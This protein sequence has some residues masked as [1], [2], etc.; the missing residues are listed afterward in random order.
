VYNN[1]GTLKDGMTEGAPSAR[2]FGVNL[3]MAD[4]LDLAT[5]DI[6]AVDGRNNW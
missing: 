1:D 4:D 6:A 2:I 3:R 5:I